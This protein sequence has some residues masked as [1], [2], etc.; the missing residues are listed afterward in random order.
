MFQAKRTA[1]SIAK[2]AS[3]WIRKIKNALE[4]VEHLIGPMTVSV[5]TT[6]TT[7]VVDGIRETA[8]AFPTKRT[9]S[10][11]VKNARFLLNVL[12]TNYLFI[13]LPHHQP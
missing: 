5:M 11:S 9:N 2:S 7:V 10:S 4:R 6:T 12:P 13:F 1:T 8:V 3:V